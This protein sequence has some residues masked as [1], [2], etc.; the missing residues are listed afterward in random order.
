MLFRSNPCYSFAIDRLPRTECFHQWCNLVKTPPNDRRTW[1]ETIAPKPWLPA[2]PHTP[3][4]KM[5]V[6]SMRYNP[7]YAARAGGAFNVRRIHYAKGVHLIE[8][9]RGSWVPQIRQEAQAHWA[10][11]HNPNNNTRDRFASLG[12]FEWCW[13]WANPFGRAG[14]MTGDAL[15]LML[16]KHIHQ[17]GTPIHIRQQYYHMD[18][19]CLLTPFDEYVDKRQ[20]DMSHGFREKFPMKPPSPP[21][22]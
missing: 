16:Q 22:L 11:A 9:P 6:W 4:E 14:A 7:I 13:V 18:C 1:D 2:G 17:Q 5:D 10:F 3:F 20:M 15:S 19:E 8:H 21:S 12:A